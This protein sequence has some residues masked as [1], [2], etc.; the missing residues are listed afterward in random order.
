MYY[1]VN[2]TKGKEEVSKMT[3]SYYALKDT[4]DRRS[5]KVCQTSTLKE[6]RATLYRI[7]KSKPK[8]Q[9]TFYYI[10]DTDGNYKGM[11]CW[12]GWGNRDGG[13]MQF[14]TDKRGVYIVHKDGTTEQE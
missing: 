8:T 5:S 14:V 1:S 9:S 3:K 4:T 13:H 10:F 12:T 2:P 6:C 11:F 7:E